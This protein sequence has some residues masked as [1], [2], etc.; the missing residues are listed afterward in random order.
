M[1]PDLSE[2][3]LQTIQEG[4]RRKYAEVAQAG[5]GL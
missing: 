3:D 5:D 4:I 1:K 2:T